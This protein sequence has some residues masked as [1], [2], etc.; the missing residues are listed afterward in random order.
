MEVVSAAYREHVVEYVLGRLNIKHEFQFPDSS[1]RDTVEAVVDYLISNGTPDLVSIQD[2][3]FGTPVQEGPKQWFMDAGRSR[4]QIAVGNGRFSV[5]IHG[6][7]LRNLDA[8]L[9]FALSITTEALS[10]HCFDKG[11][12][13]GLLPVGY[14]LVTKILDIKELKSFERCVF[15]QAAVIT[16]KDKEK[17]F[18][19][20]D[21]KNCFVSKRCL[22]MH[23]FFCDC[24]DKNTKTCE[25]SQEGIEK[26]LQTLV[27]KGAVKYV[28]TEKPKYCIA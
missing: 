1:I 20:E 5:V 15:C 2:E 8:L 21:I 24:F 17:H 7:T 11:T 6:S 9:C 25:I 27:E 18:Y 26:A 28:P 3:E 4:A 19:E 16:K 23:D 14:A 10:Y 22:H 12:L 13:A